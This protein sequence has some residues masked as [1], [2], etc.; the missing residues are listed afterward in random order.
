MQTSEKDK[1]EEIIRK[2]PK[3]YK[4]K[5][6]ASLV[7]ENDIIRHSLFINGIDLFYFFEFS[8]NIRDPSIEKYFQETLALTEAVY[9]IDKSKG[10]LTKKQVE[11]VIKKHSIINSSCKRNIF[12]LKNYLKTRIWLRKF[13]KIIS[14]REKKLNN[15]IFLS[16]DRFNKTLK[17]DNFNYGKIINLL[18]KTKTP[19]TLLEY[20]RLWNL[21]SVKNAMKKV[22]SKKYDSYHVSFLYNNMLKNTRKKFY[23]DIVNSWEKIYLT[24]EKIIYKGFNLFPIV[25]KRLYFIFNIIGLFVSDLYTIALEILKNNPKIIV[26]DSEKN[27]LAKMINLLKTPKTKTISIECD[28]LYDYRRIFSD[29]KCVSGKASEQFIINEYKYPKNNIIITGAPKYDNLMTEKENVVEEFNISQEQKIVV[30]CSQ[31]IEDKK[32]ISNLQKAQNA[33]KQSLFIIY[34]LHPRDERIIDLKKLERKNFVITKDYNT[35]KLIK[36]CD[37]FITVYSA[38][39]LEAILLD[40]PLTLYNPEGKYLELSFVKE[41]SALLTKNKIELKKAMDACLNN[42]NV[43]KRLE[44]KRKKSQKKHNYKNDGKASKRVVD[45]IKKLLK[46]K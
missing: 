6:I 18:E 9:L 46:E 20:D 31:Q 24:E 21:H 15:I 45:L 17:K 42:K 12:I 3:F 40:K 30:F 23:R 13:M 39:A 36:G 34:K 33:N 41:G 10:I 35:T 32:V 27:H 2:T 5:K 38:T 16:N 19:H 37:V 28:E 43:I 14:K 25:K 8:L 7:L 1:T 22:L 4:R 26:I 29:Y 44:I 11:K